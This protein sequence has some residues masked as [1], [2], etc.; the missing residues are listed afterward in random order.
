V[1]GIEPRLE[2]ETKAQIYPPEDLDE[3]LPTA[4]FVVTTVPHTP[5]TELMWNTARFRLMKSSAYF[6]NIGRGKTACLDDLVDALQN[7][8]IGVPDSTYLKKNRFRKRIRCY[9]TWKT[10]C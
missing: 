2:H 7:E 4:D 6:I 10:F 5:E 8:D 3:L 9:G 1:I